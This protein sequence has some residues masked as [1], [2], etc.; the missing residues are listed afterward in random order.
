[1]RG[2]LSYKGSTRPATPDVVDN[3]RLNTLPNGGWCE[4]RRD[5]KIDDGAKISLSIV[6]CGGA[7]LARD[8]V[9]HLLHYHE[10]YFKNTIDEK[11]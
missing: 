3:K 6:S 5:L 2:K 4:G 11:C 1:M 7:S 10:P 8:L 9:T